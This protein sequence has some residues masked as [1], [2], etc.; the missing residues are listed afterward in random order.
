MFDIKEVSSVEA[1]GANLWALGLSAA[2]AIGSAWL[3]ASIPA[4]LAC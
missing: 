3:V 4:I 2:S 1:T